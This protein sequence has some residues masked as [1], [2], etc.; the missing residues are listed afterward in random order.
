[1]LLNS[2]SS[3]NCPGAPP[4]RMTVS[5]RGYVC[6]KSDSVKLR[7]Y[8]SRSGSEITKLSPG[9]GFYV[10]DGPSCSDNWSWWKIQADDGTVLYKTGD[11]YNPTG[12]YILA[13]ITAITALMMTIGP[14]GGIFAG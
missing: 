5:G 4:Q 2:N 14:K 10:L 7:D 11:F 8:P 1:M 6:T 9:T 13:G 3:N 12:F